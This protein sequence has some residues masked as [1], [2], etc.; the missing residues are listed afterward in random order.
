M[1]E[2]TR[3][4]IF[5]PFFSTRKGA[6]GAGLGLAIVERIVSGHGGL[7]SVTSGPGEGTRIEAVFPAWDGEASAEVR[8]ETIDA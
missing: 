2:V 5:E 4:R 3:E 8:T 7:L 6:D 1:D